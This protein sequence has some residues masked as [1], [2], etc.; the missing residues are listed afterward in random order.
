[1]KMKKIIA[2]V[3]ALVLVAGISIGGTVAYLQDTDSDVNVMTMH[4]VHIAQEEYERVFDANGEVTGMQ[5]FD[6]NVNHPLY[7]AVITGDATARNAWA[8]ANPANQADLFWYKNYLSADYPGG[9]GLWENLNNVQ[10][11]FVFVKNTGTTDA[12][13]R[14]IILLEADTTGATNSITGQSLIHL[15]TNSHSQFTWANNTGDITD[16]TMVVTVNGKKYTVEVATC[17]VALEPGKISR[18]SLLQIGM[19]QEATNEYVAQFGETYDVLVLSQAVQTAGFE[20]ANDALNTAFGEVTAE[21]V[22]NW[23]ADIAPVNQQPI[24]ND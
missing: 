4:N 3:L 19:D 5:E 7:P 24:L 9:N 15:N 6:N 12:Y 11:K 8:P 17:N 21:N 18:P 1:M 16:E 2:T 20:N 10:D 23:F 14:T 22:Q 13:Y